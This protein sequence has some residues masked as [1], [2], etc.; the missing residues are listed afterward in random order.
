[1][2]SSIIN[3]YSKGYSG[4]RGTF[5]SSV[6]V[7]GGNLRHTFAEGAEVRFLR[8]TFHILSNYK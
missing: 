7:Q 5:A 2:V 6:E 1:M 8:M 3:V 4:K